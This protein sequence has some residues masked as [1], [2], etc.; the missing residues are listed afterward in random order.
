MTDPTRRPAGAPLHLLHLL[1]LLK[2]LAVPR[3]VA[4]PQSAPNL[5]TTEGLS[6]EAKKHLRFLFLSPVAALALLAAALLIS[7]C[8]TY[9]VVAADRE[10]IPLVQRPDGSFV[11]GTDGSQ[12]WYVPDAVMLRLLEAD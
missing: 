12:G 4:R 2:I 10:V 3:A 7:G 6:S 5:R 9:T 1:N 11:E 8:R